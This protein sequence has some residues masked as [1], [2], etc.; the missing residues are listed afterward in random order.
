M[1]QPAIL[2]KEEVLQKLHE[3]WYDEKY[4]WIYADGYAEEWTIDTNN[5]NYTQFVS[6]YKDKILG[7]IQY[8]TMRGSRNINGLTI[9]GFE[10]DVL[11]IKDVLQAIDDIFNK[12][13]FHKINFS[14]ALDNPSARIYDKYIT[15]LGGEM[16][17]IC[18][19]Q[20]LMSDGCYHHVKNYEI[21]NHN[22]KGLKN[23][24][25]TNETEKETIRRNKV[26][27]LLSSLE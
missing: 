19:E 11:F 7:F 17:G 1:L 9:I 13:H 24:R 25:G 6:V 14:S 20:W 5:W 18:K 8:H 16:Y 10:N 12:Y 23:I 4:K 3:T 2:Y 21:L 27:R 26:G 22:Y 15:K